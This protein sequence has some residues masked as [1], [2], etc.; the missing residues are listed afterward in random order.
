MSS[1]QTRLT[2]AGFTSQVATVARKDLEIEARTGVAVGRMVPFAG[3]LVVLFAIALDPDSGLLPRLA[4]GLFWIAVL[5][6]AL[7]AVARSFAIEREHRAG[8]ALIA[9]GLDPAAMFLGKSSAIAVELLALELL[10]GAT[11][12]VL[13]DVSRPG[14]AIVVAC[15]LLAS[16]GIACAG[17]LYGALTMTDE[18]R[19]NLLAVLLLPALV[20][21][22]VAATR[23]FEIAVDVGTGTARTW[24][25][26]LGVFAA[27]YASLGSLAFASL[28]EET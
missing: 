7:M 6:S 20:P 15:L 22:M 23:A 19:D 18:G 10:V 13:Y 16:A 8:E 26:L 25:G 28:V 5:L 1:S 14:A 4:P 17:T 12:V 21:L 27:V 24:I 9:A 2:A 11:M 3:I